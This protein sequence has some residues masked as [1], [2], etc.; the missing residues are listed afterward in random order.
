MIII[1]IIVVF[2][3]LLLINSTKNNNNI[4]PNKT[5]TQRTNDYYKNSLKKLKEETEG[6]K[7]PTVHSLVK[8]VKTEEDLK[9]LE[10]ETDKW[11]DKYQETGYECSTYE[12]LFNNYEEALRRLYYK[13]FYY[14]YVP[15]IELS[16]PPKV[17]ENA[18]KVIMADDLKKENKIVGG[19]EDDWNEIQGRELMD[20]SLEVLIEQKPAY[21]N[22][23]LT[24]RQIVDSD[25]TYEEKVKMINN[26]SQ[27]DKSFTDEFFFLDEDEL[28]GEFWIKDII[29]SYGVPLV[30]QLYDLGYNTPSK[31][32][33]LD[34]E[35]I[36]KIN[37]FGPKRIEKLKKAI[38]EMKNHIS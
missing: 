5:A 9:T 3:V 37:G 18:Y 28:A 21:W 36:I 20:E 13:V 24:F 4:L 2:I 17:I 38:E 27:A 23:L 30:D 29:R 25:T 15:E 12:K 14:Q 33:E 32:L 16:S 22:S 11:F 26:L 8:S 7:V 10:E 35:S 1:L 34:I 6:I 19:I 31:Y